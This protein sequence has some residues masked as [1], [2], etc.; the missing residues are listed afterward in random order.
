MWIFTNTNCK[1]VS[2][3]Y[4]LFN[5]LHIILIQIQSIVE[6]EKYFVDILYLVTINTVLIK[7]LLVD[8]HAILN[9]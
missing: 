4:F 8:K 1:S 9:Q 5:E 6:H 2:L 3:I 7:S